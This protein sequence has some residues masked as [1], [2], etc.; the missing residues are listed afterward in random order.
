MDGISVSSDR[1]HND[2]TVLVLKS[3]GLLDRDSSTLDSLFEDASRVITSESNVLD[4]ISMLGLV[5]THLLV[6]RLEGRLEHVADVSIANY[7]RDNISIAS[8]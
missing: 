7:V 2:L 8:L 6:V 3:G 5:V 4:S 1:R